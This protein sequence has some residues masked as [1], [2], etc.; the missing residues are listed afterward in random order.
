MTLTGKPRQPKFW[1]KEAPNIGGLIVMTGGKGL[2][3]LSVVVETRD[4]LIKHL[5]A[6]EPTF[7]VKDLGNGHHYCFI[8]PPGHPRRSD[9]RDPDVGVP[10]YFQLK[11]IHKGRDLAALNLF[12]RC[13]HIIERG[14]MSEQ[15]KVV[16]M[17]EY[18]AVAGVE[19]EARQS[20]GKKPKK[21]RVRTALETDLIA[22]RRTHPGETFDALLTGM[23]G[24]GRVS[25]FHSGQVDGGV[26][27]WVDED[28][29]EQRTPR[30]TVA[31]WFT[32]A[33][34]TRT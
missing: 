13:L 31:R 4:R 29:I 28:E 24:T 10:Y 5:E 23:Q 8:M 16:F 7:P 2:L 11:D 32:K 20:A 3:M 26:I 21:P 14:S 30:K 33:G 19:A 12:L 1:A 22:A 17:S 27:F 9:I 34:K 6:V 18:L 25:K 15:D